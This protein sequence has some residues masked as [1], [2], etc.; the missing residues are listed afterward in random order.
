MSRTTPEITPATV[1]AETS[2]WRSSAAKAGKARRDRARSSVLRAWATSSPII[3]AW[4]ERIFSRW[5]GV[6]TPMGRPA[7]S[8]TAMWRMANRSMRARA[9]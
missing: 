3:T 4:R 8:V 6:I 1:A 5:R 7:W 9:M 2:S